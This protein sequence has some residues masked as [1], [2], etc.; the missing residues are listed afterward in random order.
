[1]ANRSTTG[2]RLRTGQAIRVQRR[3]RRG[4][5][6]SIMF[7]AISA[8]FV[9]L[10]GI[11]VVLSRGAAHDV[12]NA[13]PLTGMAPD[14]TLPSVNGQPV[15][16][17]S[18]KGQSNVLLYFNEGY[19]CAPCWQQAHDIQTRRADLAAADTEF[20]NIMVDPPGLIRDEVSRWNLT[21][22]VLSDSDRSVSRQYNM[23]GFGMHANKP[24]HTFVFIDKAGEILWW[25][26]YP[27]MRASTDEVMD[28]IQELSGKGS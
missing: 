18:Y 2:A 14:F 6:Q 27:S 24:N 20:F 25:Q 10:A 16:L 19:G 28:T 1:M 21:M 22:P 11:L 12:G 7:V 3:R 23:L 9:V 26:D 8:S 4:V 13:T 17:S 5:A 15:T